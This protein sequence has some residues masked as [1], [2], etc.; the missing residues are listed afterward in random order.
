MQ[1]QDRSLGPGYI[2]KLY[3]AFEEVAVGIMKRR[4]QIYQ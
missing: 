2:I 1:C 4:R 3:G